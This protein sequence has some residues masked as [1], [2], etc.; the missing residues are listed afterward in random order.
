MDRQEA[1]IEGTNRTS[2]WN[3]TKVS[4]V[5]REL[6]AIATRRATSLIYHSER[7]T[8]TEEHGKVWITQ[9]FDFGDLV[10][11]APCLDPWLLT[12]GKKVYR[13]GCNCNAVLGFSGLDPEH[14]GFCG[15]ASFVQAWL[16]MG[17]VVWRRAATRQCWEIRSR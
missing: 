10:D 9:T 7:S 2:E 11:D 12:I 3:E 13:K 6:I 16:T 17:K 15:T 1:Q 4:V 8:K 5:D 14:D